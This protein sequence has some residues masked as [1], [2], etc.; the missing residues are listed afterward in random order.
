MRTT[1]MGSH[2]YKGSHQL[3]NSLGRIRRG[4]LVGG[5]IDQM[6]N[7]PKREKC[8]A[9]S[10]TGRKEPSKFFVTGQEDTGFEVGWDG[11]RS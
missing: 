7:L 3:V 2:I 11:F 6:W 8:I 5:G 10:E 1:P 4:G 9:I